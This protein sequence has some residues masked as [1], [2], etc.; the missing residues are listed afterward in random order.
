[1]TSRGSEWR[2][3]AGGRVPFTSL[4][5]LF[6]IILLLV[7]CGGWQCGVCGGNAG[8]MLVSGMQLSRTP[9]EVMPLSRTSANSA[10][11]TKVLR[12]PRGAGGF[13]PKSSLRPRGAIPCQHVGDNTNQVSARAFLADTVFEGK[14]RSRSPVRDKGTYAV[15]FVVQRVHKDSSRPAGLRLRLRSQVRLHF[16]ERTSA[17]GGDSSPQD[18]PCLQSYN[19]T[20]RPGELLRTNI[21]RGG[22]YLVFAKG[23]GPHNFSVLGEPVFRSRKNLKAVKEVL[24]DKCVRPAGVWGLEDVKVKVGERL[25][26]VCRCKGNPLPAIQ[27]F[28]DGSRVNA[29]INTRIK[30]K[31][32]RSLLVIP[33]VSLS[34]S[35]R[36]ECKATDVIGNIYTSSATVTITTDNTTTL[37]PLNGAPCPIESYCLNGGTC[38]YY[39][40]VGEW[41]C[42]CAEGYKGPRCESKDVYNKSSMYRPMTYICKLGISSSY[43]C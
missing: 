6:L 42:Q 15:T 3:G 19:F 28:K 32:K 30:Y 1:M 38:T 34:D 17:S 13:A 12:W 14:A 26:L 31:K 16:K 20:M 10:L 11:R 23:V 41:V 21:K 5:A 8:G 36:Y 43:Y 40:T 39:E 22:K 29:T 27:W 7:C 37:W 35:G 33:R 2:G 25:R 18:A 4:G 9:S 24:C